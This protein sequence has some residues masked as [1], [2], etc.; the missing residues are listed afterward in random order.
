MTVI[1]AEG[2]DMISKPTSACKCVEVYYKH[3]KPPTCFGHSCDHLQGGAFIIST[4]ILCLLGINQFLMFHNCALSNSIWYRQ[5][6]SAQS[7]M[8]VYY[9]PSVPHTCL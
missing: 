1:E 2:L 7:C 8:N 6:T 5:P 4:C 9:K 3:S